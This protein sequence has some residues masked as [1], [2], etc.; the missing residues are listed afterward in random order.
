MKILL[1]FAFLIVFDSKSLSQDYSDISFN[2]YRNDSKIGHH[3]VSF[4][5]IES[6][7]N[8]FIDIN[9]IVK[10]LGITIY[11][12]EHLNQE[13]WFN[14]NLVSINSRTNKNGTKLYCELANIK[15]PTVPSSYWNYVLVSD[16][17]ITE[18]KNTQDC[19]SIKIQISNLGRELIYND[20]LAAEHFK[21][22]GKEESG[23]TVDIDVWYDQ[24]KKWVKMIFIKGDSIIEYFLDEY[25]DRK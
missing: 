4:D 25:D 13:K 7:L 19:S 11:R 1:L 20:T 2:V 9:F 15:N 5:I 24:N 22:I 3:K 17:N 18:L 12:Y 6:E 14:N 10:F 21:I 8:V 23:E 16:K